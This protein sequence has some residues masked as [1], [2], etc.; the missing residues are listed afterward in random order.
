MEQHKSDHW[1]NGG[2]G[3]TN[4]PP[5]DF[6]RYR[7]AVARFGSDKFLVSEERMI[8]RGSN[9]EGGSLHYLGH[10]RTDEGEEEISRFWQVF[11]AVTEE[12]KQQ[13]A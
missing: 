5:Q 11:D 2:T 12:L 4:F 8:G 7:E 10:F 3:L 6:L 1:T 13:A 9:C